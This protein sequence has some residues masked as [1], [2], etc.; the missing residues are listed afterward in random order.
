MAVEIVQVP[1]GRAP[2]RLRAPGGG[3]PGILI[4]PVAL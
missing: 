2:N 4:D 3:N 1:V